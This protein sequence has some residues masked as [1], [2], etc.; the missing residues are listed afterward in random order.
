MLLNPRP[1]FAISY[2]C[3]CLQTQTQTS[4]DPNKG[5]CVRIRKVTHKS[6]LSGVNW[7]C[8]F[9]K[10]LCSSGCCVVALCQVVVVHCGYGLLCS[11]RPES[12]LDPQSDSK[13]QWR[14]AAQGAG[15]VLVQ[16][17]RSGGPRP[18]AAPCGRGGTARNKAQASEGPKDQQDHKSQ[19]WSQTEP[20]NVWSYSLPQLWWEAF[21]R[22]IS[23]Q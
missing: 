9:T 23:T 12:F 6:R 20:G 5:V 16:R 2:L 14:G 11:P 10:T 17:A 13:L 4:A 22:L 8:I 19:P 18:G 3:F 21:L 7:F 1:F 15:V